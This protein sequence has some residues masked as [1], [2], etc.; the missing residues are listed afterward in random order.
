MHI[1]EIRKLEK[2]KY[3]IILDKDDYVIL[4]YKELKA[5]KMVQGE[6]IEEDTWE[7]ATKAMTTRGKKRV[8][9]LLCKKDYVIEEIRKKLIKE[10]YPVAIIE[11]ILAYFI[12]LGFLNDETYIEKYYR[13]QKATKSRRMIEMKLSEKGMPRDTIKAFFETVDH[14]ETD[15]ETAQKLL[16]KKYNNK[17]VTRQEYNKMARFLAYKG[18]DY[19]VIQSVIMTYLKTKDES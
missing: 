1:E 11:A 12:K 16:E 3:K 15:Y 18:F 7:L 9:H 2:G 4:Y 6:A 17:A 13:Y 8:Y 5:F 14:R 10:D 19:D